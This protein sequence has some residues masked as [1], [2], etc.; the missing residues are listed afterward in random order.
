MFMF[1][2][3]AVESLLVIITGVLDTLAASAR[4]NC[5]GSSGTGRRDTGIDNTLADANRSIVLEGSKK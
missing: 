4:E 2:S 1:A 5:I 3:L